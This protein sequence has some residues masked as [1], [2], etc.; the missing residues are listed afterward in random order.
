[1]MLFLPQFLVHLIQGHEALLLSPIVIIAFLINCTLKVLCDGR[2]FCYDKGAPGIAV[3]GAVMAL[4]A[5]ERVVWFG[6]PRLRPRR[7]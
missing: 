6:R 7:S 2:Q 4:V 3:P 1:M 5:V